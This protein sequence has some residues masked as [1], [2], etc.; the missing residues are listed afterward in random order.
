MTLRVHANS[1][2]QESVVRDAGTTS[3][4]LTAVDVG[5]DIVKRLWPGSVL[6][7][8]AFVIVNS[9]MHGRFDWRCSLGTAVLTGSGMG[10]LVL[11]DLIL[12]KLFSHDMPGR[13]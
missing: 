8:A 4:D 12:W 9:S 7:F 3:E 5:M 1:F 10:A 13:P 2:N 6:C 11:R